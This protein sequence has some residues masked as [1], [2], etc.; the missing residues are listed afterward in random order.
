MYC[1]QISQL[2]PFS[3]TTTFADN[4]TDDFIITEMEHAYT[5]A[6]ELPYVRALDLPPDVYTLSH[7]AARIKVRLIMN[8]M[9]NT[10]E[11]PAAASHTPALGHKAGL[12]CGVQ[13]HK[14]H[15]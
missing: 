11:R 12:L 8:G 3:Q 5:V 13:R 6:D 1:L 4:L 14:L 15:L 7:L 2:I 10:N 9:H